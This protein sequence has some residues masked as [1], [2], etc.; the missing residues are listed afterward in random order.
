MNRNTLWLAGTALAL[1]TAGANAQIS[2]S[3]HNF[4]SMG[5]SGGEICKP[6]HT[7]HFSDETAIRLWNHELTTATYTLNGGTTTTAATGFDIASRMCLSCHDGTVALDSFGGQTGTNFMPTAANLGT[8]LSNDHPVGGKA[9]YP[10]TSTYMNPPSST[11]TTVTF[12]ANTL[13]LKAWVDTTGTT[14]YVVGCTTCHTPH[15]RG[16]YGHMTS[17]SNASSG[18]CLTCHIK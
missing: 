18:L 11:G 14:K 4:S 8:D 16:N 15:N 3:R 17:V 7:P 12:G 2:V 1:L 5:W 9:I 6:C 13:R 10:T